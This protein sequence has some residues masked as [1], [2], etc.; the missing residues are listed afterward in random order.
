M[1]AGGLLASGA[2]EVSCIQLWPDFRVGGT[3]CEAFTDIDGARS[4][5]PSVAVCQLVVVCFGEAFVAV[6]CG[7]VVFLG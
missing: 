5:R 7:F 4:L 3:A 6:S 2:S 1:Q